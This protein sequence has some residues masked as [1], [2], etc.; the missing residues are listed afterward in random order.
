MYGAPT[1]L[2]S[3]ETNLK[4]KKPLLVTASIGV[5]IAFFVAM[6]STNFSKLLDVVEASEKTMESFNARITTLPRLVKG[7]DGSSQWCVGDA[8]NLK[9]FYTEGSAIDFWY[10]G[11][12]NPQ[13]EDAR[14]QLLI[15]RF[16]IEETMVFPMFLDLKQARNLFLD[17]VDAWIGYLENASQCNNYEDCFK[18]PSDINPTF[19]IAEKAL[20]NAI[21]FSDNPSIAKRVDS[22]FID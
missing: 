22:I 2:P 8:Q 15:D 5:L 3:L 9:C 21:W 7:G 6:H 19:K 4:F 1:I 12:V 20:L 18:R 11:V 14:R 16:D 13:A 10:Q 17:H